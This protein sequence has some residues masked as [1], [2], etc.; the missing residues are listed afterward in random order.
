MVNDMVL[1]EQIFYTASNDS[2]TEYL[3]ENNILYKWVNYKGLR[4]WLARIFPFIYSI[5]YFIPVYSIEVD[6]H[7]DNSIY[8]YIGFFKS[9]VS[10]NTFTVSINGVTYTGILRQYPKLKI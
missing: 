8:D 1:V 2:A 10:G 3:F 7:Q 4:Y 5:G 6:Y 9:T